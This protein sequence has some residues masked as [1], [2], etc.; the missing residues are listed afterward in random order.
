M[1]DYWWCVI[2]FRIL[3]PLVIGIGKLNCSHFRP[4]YT[5]LI[6][7]DSYLHSPINYFLRIPG[8]RMLHAVFLGANQKINGQGN[9]S[10]LESFD[11]YLRFDH[12]VSHQF[13]HGHIFSRRKLG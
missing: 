3:L 7:F 9:R 11:D 13:L 12:R 8:G 4:V 1:D 10:L 6:V 2:L 5:L